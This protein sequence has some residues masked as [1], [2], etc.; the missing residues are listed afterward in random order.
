MDSQSKLRLELVAAWSGVVFIVGYPIFWLLMAMMQPPIPYSMPPEEMADF[1]ISHRSRIMYGMAI[2]SIIGGTWLTFTAQLTV[3]LH[4]IE[5]EGPVFT[6]INFLGGV[7]AGW[8]LIFTPVTWMMPAM[9]PDGDPQVIRAFNDYSYLLF[10]GTFIISSL[11]A[12]AHG[13]VGLLD[14][15]SY[16]VFPRWACWV[17][18]IAGFGFFFVGQTPFVESGSFALDGWFAGWVPGTG[19]FIWTIVTTYYMIK[20]IKRRM[21]SSIALE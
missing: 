12:W 9:R 20:D 18:I 7:L 4:R 8:A 14:R 6:I 10:N 1:Y 13:V 2:S 16:R 21:K 17:A 15:S 11:Q 19:Y 5:G 3:V